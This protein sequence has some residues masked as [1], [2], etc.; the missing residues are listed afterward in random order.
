MREVDADQDD[1]V[2][3]LSAGAGG[4]AGEHL[5]ARAVG[6]DGV[7][8][9][10]GRGVAGAAGEGDAEDDG[11]GCGADGILFELDAVAESGG[12]GRDAGSGAE[13]VL[14]LVGATGIAEKPVGEMSAGAAAAG[15]DWAGAGG[16][17]RAA[18]DAA[19]G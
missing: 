3:V 12:D 1:D 18:D 10:A 6:P 13:E 16:S 4:N 19:A 17:A 8:E 15:D 2:R 11:A 14:E 7:E 9:A 5:R